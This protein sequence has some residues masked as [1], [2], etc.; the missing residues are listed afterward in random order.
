MNR[1]K[2]SSHSFFVFL[3]NFR[4]NFCDL[5]LYI[6]PIT[7]GRTNIEG[8]NIQSVLQTSVERK[9]P[10]STKTF[11]TKWC[12]IRFLITSPVVIVVIVWPSLKWMT[13]LHPWLQADA[14]AGG[15]SVHYAR[16]WAG[17]W[18]F[19]T[20]LIQLTPLVAALF[21]EQLQRQFGPSTTKNHWATNC[22][23]HE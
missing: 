12:S 9:L 4:S 17:G 15:G 19:I 1:V 23:F 2:R 20:C 5:L 8:L 22:L 3:T 11:K 7:Y 16:G 21:W 13:S 18:W 6:S 10:L 14:R